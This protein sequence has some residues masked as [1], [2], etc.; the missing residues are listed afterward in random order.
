MKAFPIAY[1]VEL[2][3]AM[4]VATRL[5]AREGRRALGTRRQAAVATRPALRAR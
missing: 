2:F 1:P 5:G 3:V 4:L